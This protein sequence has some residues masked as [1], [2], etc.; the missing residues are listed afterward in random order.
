MPRARKQPPICVLLGGGGHARV[1]IE[2]LELMGGRFS[3]V[4]LDTDR[5]L[6]G[7]SILGVKVA[8]GEQRMGEFV[9]QGRETHFVVALG[10][11]GTGHTRRRLFERALACGLKPLGICHPTAVV[12]PSATVGEGS[13]LLAGSFLGA[14]ASL[15]VNVIVN[16]GA[17][18]E[19]DCRIGDHVHI[20]TGARLASTI[21]V[22]D[23]TLIGVGAAVRQ[24]LN[25]GR[26]VVVG[27]GTVVVRSIRD[28]LTVVGNPGR[29][30]R[31]K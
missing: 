12:S 23:A 9:Q 18:V 8:G 3:C 10:T 25:I 17:I 16:N 4:I 24:C 2:C 15:G 21:E 30:I 27:A 6:W 13:Q 5:R 26:G 14:G 19:H 7:A 20:A 1:I 31:R 11:V 28:G 22:G 29:P